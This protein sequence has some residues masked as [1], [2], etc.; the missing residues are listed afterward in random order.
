MVSHKNRF[1]IFIYKY[2]INIIG[3]SSYVRVVNNSFWKRW[4]IGFL[5]ISAPFKYTLPLFSLWQTQIHRSKGFDHVRINLFVFFIISCFSGD[6]NSINCFCLGMKIVLFLINEMFSNVISTIT[7]HF[8][9]HE[10][11]FDDL[12]EFNIC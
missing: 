5:P 2:P 11:S 3:I 4:K 1:W 7:A 9:I 10:T 8:L 6:C 12:V